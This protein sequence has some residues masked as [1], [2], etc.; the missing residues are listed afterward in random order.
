MCTCKMASHL[1]PFVSLLLPAVSLVALSQKNSVN[2]TCQTE[3]EQIYDTVTNSKLCKYSYQHDMYG[4]SNVMVDSW[5]L[6]LVTENVIVAIL[7]QQKPHMKYD[8]PS[9]YPTVCEEMIMIPCK[10]KNL[11]GVRPTANFTA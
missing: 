4:S 6:V 9:M 1:H 5:G 7:C 11:E 3:I 2:C 8:L 10:G